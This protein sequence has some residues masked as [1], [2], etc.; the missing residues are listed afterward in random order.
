[1]RR[2][3]ITG[4][5]VG[6]VGVGWT[7]GSLSVP[8]GSVAGA[9]TPVVN[10]CA[11][12]VPAM[13]PSTG[14]ETPSGFSLQM[15]GVTLA[16]A[17]DANTLASAYYQFNDMICSKYSHV[18]TEAPPDF[19]YYDC[20]GFTGYTTRQ[21]D[22]AA[23]QSVVS[24]LNLRP[25]FVPT[26]LSFE[27]FFN[28]LAAVPRNGWQ[29][30]PN[31]QSIAPG[32]ILAWQPALSNGQPD[33]DGVGHSVIPLVAP[34]AIPGSNNERWEVVIMDSTAGGHGPDDTR[35]PDNPLSERN[36]P[37]V[38]RRGDVEPSGLGIGTIALDTDSGGNVTGVEWNV[39]DAPE[40]IVFGAGHPEGAP[41]PGPVPVPTPVPPQVPQGYDVVASDGRVT[42]F[43]DAYNY[44]PDGPLTLNKPVVGMA[45]T[46]DGNGYWEVA[47]DGGV[48]SFG[49]ALF[50]GSTGG[51]HLNQPVVGIAGTQDQAGYWL[52]A[53]D[54]GVFTF[55]DAQF[56][57]STG[58]LTL[59]RPIVGMAPTPD[60]KG[61]WLVASD[62]G[63]FTFGDAEFFGSTG[64]LT[65]NRPI[66]GMAPTPDGRGYWL[67]ASDGGIFAFGGAPFYGSMGSQPLNAPVVA[68][69]GSPDGGGYWLLAADGGV[70]GFGDA[71]FQGGLGGTDLG[72]SPIVGVAEA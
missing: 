45:V 68:V 44:G 70:F 55:G 29:A 8:A 53:G 34:Q 25:G 54:G 23:W 66:V 14:T 36:A 60:G 5:V 69:V 16:P 57:G 56:F 9:S 2:S 15:S 64:G 43:G 27:K 7:L 72:G 11:T 61:Y 13:P 6:L 48:F 38:T 65:L 49:T 47:S 20:V 24:A 35:K 4:V 21:A 58:G 10:D 71:E 3:I 26:P 52:V 63:V 37:I 33:T 46:V 67:V 39:G 62:G 42:S 31:V 22:P 41:G 40:P 32:D 1:M 19:Y 17:S 30:V 51:Q 28:G 12:T 59:N 18:Y 50:Y